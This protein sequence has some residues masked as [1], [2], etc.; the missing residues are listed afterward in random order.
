[1]LGAAFCALIVPL[2]CAS[3]KG[4]TLTPYQLRSDSGWHPYRIAPWENETNNWRCSLSLN[5]THTICCPAT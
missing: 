3:D 1:M 4:V 2:S 5:T